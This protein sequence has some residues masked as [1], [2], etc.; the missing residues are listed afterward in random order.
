MLIPDV[1]FNI[2]VLPLLPGLLI[3]NSRGL[4]V[5]HM[6]NEQWAYSCICQNVTKSTIPKPKTD[7]WR[8]HL[9]QCWR[10]LEELGIGATVLQSQMETLSAKLK[11][12][13]TAL[14]RGH[15]REKW[16]WITD[17]NTFPSQLREIWYTMLFHCSVGTEPTSA[18][19]WTPC[20]ISMYLRID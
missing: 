13:L 19:N 6:I 1:T 10:T 4:F 17:N 14:Q 5:A 20:Y 9:P 2:L 11:V 8:A 16:M 7:L 15:N 3:S 18:A 12:W